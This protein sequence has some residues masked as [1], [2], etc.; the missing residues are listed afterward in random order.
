MGYSKSPRTIQRVK[1]HLDQMVASTDRLEWPDKNPAKLSYWIR[2]G[3][4]AAKRFAVDSERKPVEPYA[5]YA[6]LAT[7]YII[8]LGDGKVVAE[9]RDVIP[10]PIETTGTGKMVLND[11]LS[12][13]ELVGAAAQHQ[14]PEMFF[15]DADE[16]S[17]NMELL[18]NWCSNNGYFIVA[19]S[20]GITLTKA[21]PGELAWKP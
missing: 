12:E 18:H 3:I 6:R 7:K 17:C 11:L 14:A 1:N 13:F 19:N 20:S 2:D 21:D 8:K 10:L 15:P 9:L 16:E 4:N 5:S